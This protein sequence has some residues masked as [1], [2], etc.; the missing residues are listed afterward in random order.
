MY[1]CFTIR[2]KH[3]CPIYLQ[4]GQKNI[5]TMIYP[6]AAYWAVKLHFSPVRLVLGLEMPLHCILTVYRHGIRFH[7][8]TDTLLTT[9]PSPAGTR[10]TNYEININTICVNVVLYWYV[11]YTFYLKHYITIFFHKYSSCLAH[12][13]CAN[14]RS[15]GRLPVRHT[16][17]ILYI[18]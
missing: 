11:N 2:S 13:C 6:S 8:C 10:G 3:Y 16:P 17:A 7:A 12:M 1:A 5:L 18:R 14:K 15:S 4:V 9:R